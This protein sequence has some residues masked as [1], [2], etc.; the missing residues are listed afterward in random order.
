MQ[1]T[2][3]A[4]NLCDILYVLQYTCSYLFQELQVD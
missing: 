2:S 4:D 1:P 3:T